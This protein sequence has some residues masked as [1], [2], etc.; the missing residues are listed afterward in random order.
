MPRLQRERNFSIIRLRRKGNNPSDIAARFNVSPAR[1]AQIVAAGDALE[2][3]RAELAKKYG[4]CPKIGQLNDRA[5]VDVLI[6]CNATIHGWAVRV[7]RLKNASN[8]IKTLGDLRK[9]TD[10]Q[11][12]REPHIGTRMLA[13]LRSFCP[14]RNDRRGKRKGRHQAVQLVDRVEKVFWDT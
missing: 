12:L 3:R 7:T 8:T 5:P 10:A 1:V 6:L 4:A 9:T 13:H 11:L 14:F 2:R